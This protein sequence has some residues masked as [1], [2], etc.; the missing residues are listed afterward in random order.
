MDPLTILATFAPFAVDLGKS[1]INRF[2]AGDTFKP[3]NISEYIPLTGCIIWDYWM[4]IMMYLRLALSVLFATSQANVCG[5][6]RVALSTPIK[7]LIYG[8]SQFH[9]FAP[10]AYANLLLLMAVWITKTCLSGE[11]G[12]LQHI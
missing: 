2:I 12:L 9:C 4:S 10:C 8:P 11:S 6:T 1:L 7:C 3:A 5:L